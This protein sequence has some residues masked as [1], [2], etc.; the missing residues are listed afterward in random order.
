MTGLAQ[1]VVWFID[2][3][4]PQSDN[5]FRETSVT[6]VESMDEGR[7]ELLLFGE[8]GTT[9]SCRW[10]R[11]AGRVD[12]ADHLSNEALGLLGT[13]GTRR[14]NSSSCGCTSSGS[15]RSVGGI[16]GLLLLERRDDRAEDR[17]DALDD[18]LHVRGIINIGRAAL[19]LLLLLAGL[20]GGGLASASGTS[21]GSGMHSL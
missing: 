8:L 19:L 14:S 20:L 16:V 11:S 18:G 15:S 6:S 4:I 17:G 1:I 13:S 2:G 9:R 10:G 21:C 7:V 5:G 3:M 12:V